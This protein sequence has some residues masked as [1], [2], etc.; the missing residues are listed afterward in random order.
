MKYIVDMAKASADFDK[1]QE[2]SQKLQFA[3]TVVLG[4]AAI[5]IAV[6]TVFSIFRGPTGVFN[7]LLILLGLFVIASY[8][9]TTLMKPL[10]MSA[11]FYKITRG[12]K[13]LQLDAQEYEQ[14]NKG[15][16]VIASVEDE[17]GDVRKYTLGKVRKVENT[18]YTEPVI[19]LEHERLYVPYVGDEMMPER[20]EEPAEETIQEI[21]ED[22]S[23]TVADSVATAEAT[24][25]E[26]VTAE[27]EATIPETE[28]SEEHK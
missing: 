22:N 10:K 6:M 26:A 9:M 23:A 13:L 20:V 18:R 11:R 24:A 28:L 15:A 2:R 1:A 17:N 14:F 21:V 27:A 3:N 12:G 19:H 25:V 8:V 4:A 5:C 16:L 7:A